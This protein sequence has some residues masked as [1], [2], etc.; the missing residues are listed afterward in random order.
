MALAPYTIEQFQGLNLAADPLEV[1]ATG[2]TALSNV[3]LDVPGRLRTRD[4][5][6]VRSTTTTAPKRIHVHS[7]ALPN[8]SHIISS[9]DTKL[10]VFLQSTGAAVAAGTVTPLQGPYAMTTFGTTSGSA[11]YGVYHTDSLIRKWSGTAWSTVA[12][13]A[14]GRGIAVS[15]ASNRLVIGG[16]TA[17]GSRVV[18]SDPGAPETFGANNVVDLTPGD[19]DFITQVQAWQDYVIAFKKRKFFVF[20]GESTD[21]DGEPIFNYRAVSGVGA[22][23]GVGTATVSPHGVYFLGAD[24]LYLTDGGAIKK[25]HGPL[26]PLFGSGPDDLAL[27]ESTNHHLEWHRDRLIM[28]LS[29]AASQYVFVYY[30]LTDSWS[31]WST[32]EGMVGGGF[33]G[34]DSSKTLW[35]VN[36]TDSAIYEMT[37]STTTD[38]GSAIAWSYTSGRY[39]L[40]DPGRVATTLESS[41]AG[42]GTVAMSVTTDLYGTLAGP[43]ATLG[44]A[45]AIA[46]GWPMT[47]QE[48]T[49]YQHTLSG[50]GP[51][52]VS[53]LT[54][55]VSFVK[56]TGIR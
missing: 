13:A 22:L 10:E 12:G 54:H 38:L 33:A 32:H 18:F 5:Y 6:A 42:S 55:H 15:R 40:S 28:M 46:E 53:R 48:G 8:V 52:L 23:E 14:L 7:S 35:F 49:W 27:S 39:P 26:S 44:T 37:P 17:H 21:S 2:A 4:G 43:G 25:V 9:S 24:G 19:G 36:G 45:P 20:T 1:G 41:V 56:P 50:S 34:S 31:S 30:P 3:A 11:V 51:A 29:T 47:D 16:T